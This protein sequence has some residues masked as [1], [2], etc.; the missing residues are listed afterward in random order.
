M[1]KRQRV[2]GGEAGTEP[3]SLEL[4]IGRNLG[5]LAEIAAKEI[6]YCPLH[7][8]EIVFNPFQGARAMPA[9]KC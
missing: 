2:Y 6:R 4:F 3:Y 7:V 9:L 1:Y 8:I 5:K